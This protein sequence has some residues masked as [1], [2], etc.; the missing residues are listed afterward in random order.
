MT[1][2]SRIVSTGS[3]LPPRKV[4]NEDLAK[5]VDTSDEWITTRTGIKSR[6]LADDEKT[7]DM[8][9]KAA[10]KALENIDISTI[11]L[12][13]LGTTTPDY[14]FPA[15]AAKVAANLGIQKAASFDVQAVCSGF[16]YALTIADKFIKSGSHKRALVIGAEKLSDILDWKDRNT[17]VLFGDGAGAVVLEVSDDGGIL[18]SDIY[19]DGSKIDILYAPKGGFLQMQGTEVF[20]NAVSKMTSSMGDLL[21]R[22]NVKPEEIDWV[23]PHQANIRILDS[24]MQY[25]GLPKEKLIVTLDKHGNTSAASIPLALDEAVRT[26]KVKRGDILAFTAV[27]GGLTW[28]SMVLKF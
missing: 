25:L 23:I 12:V 4:S 15:T 20:K 6:H 24:V 17:C 22:I 8:A 19:T 10:V 7:S 28:G 9:T 27:G 13:I 16:L 26:G 2:Y 11:D 21:T 5:I 14:I 18:G 3:Y 1:I